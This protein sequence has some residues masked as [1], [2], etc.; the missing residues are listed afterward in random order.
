MLCNLKLSGIIFFILFV[1]ADSSF[2]QVSE[3]SVSLENIKNARI[4]RF[5][6]IFDAAGEKSPVA[7]SNFSETEKSARLSER[8]NETSVKGFGN[9]AKN[10]EDLP[11][12]TE[13][14]AG[15][16][17]LRGEKEWQFE[18]GYSPFEPTH[19]AG[20]KEYNTA[21]RKVGMVNFRWGR[22]IGTKK[23]V[24][25]QYMLGFTPLAVFLKN[26]VRNKDFVS[27]TETPNVAP[28]KRETSY[29][30]AVQPVNF[31]FIFL[32]SRRIKPFAQVGAG[33]LLTNKA[34][35][36]PKSLNFQFTGDFG[37]GLIIH[38]SRKRA[39][40]LSYRYFHIS[41]GN[42]S[43]KKYN[44]GFNANVFSLSYSFFYK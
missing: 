3:K 29:G 12:E 27:P 17:F 9:T 4:I 16:R 28:T 18:F 10:E 33:V 35:P 41:N 32:S 44:V 5:G 6:K 36:L 34:V 19:F 11:D 21:G 43:E 24:T 42:F 37:G 14:P 26:E 23:G 7:E 38:A 25:Y 30:V 15:Y 8:E 40:I 1:S 31:R 39:W 22:V 13:A 20:P 2:A